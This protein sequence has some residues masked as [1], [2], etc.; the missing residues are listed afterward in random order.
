MTDHRPDFRS[1]AAL[2]ASVK[3]V[4]VPLAAVLVLMAFL[5][6]NPAAAQADD[7]Y[8]PPPG[9]GGGS[10]EQIGRAHV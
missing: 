10:F 5:I 8:R 2:R 6:P 1:L 9:G 3:A 4:L 7:A